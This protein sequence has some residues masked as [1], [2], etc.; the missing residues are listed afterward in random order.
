MLC[1]THIV[2]TV[3]ASIIKF[4]NLYLLI[5][6]IIELNATHPSFISDTLILFLL[7]HF[8]I[9]LGSLDKLVFFK[10]KSI[11]NWE[12]PYTKYRNCSEHAIEAFHLII[13]HLKSY[14]RCVFAKIRFTFKVDI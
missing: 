1:T 11:V 7:I 6:I 4:A 13:S 14:N 3:A 8:I 5:E 12:I 2:F 10:K 9:T